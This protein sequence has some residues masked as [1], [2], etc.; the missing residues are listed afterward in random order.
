MIGSIIAWTYFIIVLYLVCNIFFWFIYLTKPFDILP[1]TSPFYWVRLSFL[2][3]FW[4]VTFFVFIFIIM[5]KLL[6]ILWLIWI[7]LRYIAPPIFNIFAFIP[8]SLSRVPPLGELEDCG[9]F[10]LFNS[11][12][13]VIVNNIFSPSNPY[14]NIRSVSFAILGWLRQFIIRWAE[15]NDP[16]LAANMKDIPYNPKKLEK[17]DEKPKNNKDSIN[18]IRLKDKLYKIILENEKLCISN[19][20]V[21]LSPN[22]STLDTINK[23]MQNRIADIKCKMKFVQPKIKFA[24]MNL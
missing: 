11:I 19:S 14:E 20:K 9:L 8:L 12:V 6:L 1:G 15:D 17:I 7:V 10:G 2:T 24:L 16:E 13:M 4:V 21:S 18:V 5:T 22:D 3:N 23:K